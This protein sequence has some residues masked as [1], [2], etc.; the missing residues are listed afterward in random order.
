MTSPERRFVGLYPVLS[1]PFAEDDSIDW[2]GL[3]GVIDYCLRSGS[4]G[5]VFGLGSEINKVSLEERLELARFTRARVPQGAADVVMAVEHSSSKVAADWGPRFEELGMDA[6]M[7][8]PIGDPKTYLIRVAESVSIPIVVQDASLDGVTLPTPLLREVADVAPN[9]RYVKAE[10][11]PTAPKIRELETAGLEAIGG[12]A[13]LFLLEELDA[14][15]VCTFPGS[16]IPAAHVRILELWAEGRRAEAESL[17]TRL[18][19]FL[20]IGMDFVFLQKYVLRKAGVVRRC[21]NRHPAGAPLTPEQLAW[22]DHV[23]A[24]TGIEEFFNP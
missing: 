23:I 6:L 7:V 4:R 3:E 9:A 20:H 21:E 22:A 5:V 15:I 24:T 17:Y 11:A 13:T 18:M 16:A 1:L 19:P 14:G 2:E 8:R 12:A 10:T